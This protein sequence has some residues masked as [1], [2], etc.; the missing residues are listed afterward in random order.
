ME[1]IIHEAPPKA[2]RIKF[3]IPYSA[4]EWRSKIKALDSSFYHKNQKLWS[5]KNTSENFDKLDDIFEGNWVIKP[6]EDKKSIPTK[7][8]GEDSLNALAL[9][10]QKIIL[11]AYSEST[12]SAYRNS[13]CQFLAYFDNRDLSQVTKDEIESFV[14]MLIRKY[15]ISESKQNIMINSIKFY[16]EKVL[17]KN[18][19][20]YDI[21]RPKR[22]KSL[23]NVLSI[24]EIQALINSPQNLKHRT[25]LYLMY[26]AGLRIG[27]VPI[28]RIEDIHRDE[29]YLFIKSSKGKKDRKTVLSNIF[30][31]L[32][33]EY[34][35]SFKPSYW[36][37]EGVAGGQYSTASINSIF[38]RAV[39]AS[40]VNPWATPHT[41]RHSFA[42]HLL[43]NGTNLRFVQVL[44]GHNNP[45][46]TEI[47][48]HVMNVSNKTIKSPLD[49]LL[50]KG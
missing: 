38:R 47:Y 4:F 15:R 34:L 49:I 26:S 40:N 7:S 9:L 28:I 33:D 12:R 32:L 21:Q 41:L 10:E 20:Y 35:I 24:Q 16:Y 8:L 18:R 1:A 25:I 42:T 30:L 48:T 22:T 5:V 46:T 36:L 31:E 19:G 50:G 43:Q 39:K 3:H 13:F 14:A 2:G 17:G 29:G 37:F 6:L 27:E 23:P 45:K 11:K 44:L